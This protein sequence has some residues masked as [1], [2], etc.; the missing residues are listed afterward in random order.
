MREVR[1]A[2]R[3][4]K[5]L[6]EFAQE[7]NLVEQ[8]YSDMVQLESVC[9]SNRDFRLMLNSP[10]V[11]FDRKLVIVD[12][13]F[14]PHFNEASLK[15]LKIIVKKRREKYIPDIA[16]EY[17]RLYKDFKGIKT[18]KLVTAVQADDKTKQKVL[19]LLT[20]Y[21]KATIE[22]IEEVDEDLIGGFVL[23][24]DDKQ[25]DASIQKGVQELK[26][27]FEM[28]IYVRGF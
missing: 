21:T 2:K 26:R 14:A 11:K 16:K 1:I 23:L 4:A 9:I 17:I 24:F 5:A 20:D 6:F 25:Y 10:V 19:K 13:I 15:Y 8:V 28:N 7:E 18:V 27:D 12:E 3:Y 22:L